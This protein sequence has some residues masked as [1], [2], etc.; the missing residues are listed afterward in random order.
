MPVLVR[1]RY[2]ALAVLF[3]MPG[4]FLLGGGGGIAMVAGVS[5]LY[6]VPGFLVTVAIAVSP[7]PLAIAIFGETVIGL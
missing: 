3:N 1:H 7:V 6:S 5:R 4:N 2:V